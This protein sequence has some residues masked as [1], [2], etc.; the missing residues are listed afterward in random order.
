VGILTDE[1]MLYLPP[2]WLGDPMVY[3]AVAISFIFVL[4]V[5]I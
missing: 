1:M 5:F 3:F 4:V 2:A